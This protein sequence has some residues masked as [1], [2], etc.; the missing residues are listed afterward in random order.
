MKS[1]ES[2]IRNLDKPVP[3]WIDVAPESDFLQSI[4][5]KPLPRGT[6]HDLI[7]GSIDERS[8]RK[9]EKGDGVVTVASET[10]ARV[11]KRA[12]SSQ[13]FPWEYVD[14]LKQSTTVEQV[15]RALAR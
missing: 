9:K 10:D 7:Y 3:S 14:F 5:S 11:L 1:A 6:M 4:Y 13:H 15:E 2:G 8:I 12:R